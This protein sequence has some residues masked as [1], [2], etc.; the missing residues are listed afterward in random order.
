[1]ASN[2]GCSV[3]RRARDDAQDLGGRRLLLERLGEVPRARL[4]LLL[5]VGVGLLQPRR[6][7]VELLGEGLEL[8]ARAHLDA[9]AEVARAHA[10]GARLEGA[11][12]RDHP[13]RE[14]QA[15]HD[16]RARCRARGGARYAMA[17]ARSGSSAS[18]S[19]CSTNTVQRSGH[20]GRVRGE[21]LL[22]SCVA[23][24]VHA[25]GRWPGPG[26]PASA[27]LTWSRPD[28][29]VFWSTRLM[30]GCGDERALP[31]HHEGAARRARS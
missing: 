7:A 30:S 28:E 14:E 12:G 21:H 3:G 16:R 27:A 26:A 22:T 17:E 8:V 13:P 31:V 4:H 20:D 18:S 29:V 25:G 2:T 24:G 6:H 11:D 23:R 9:L 1:M 10:L 15:R 19:G 5:E